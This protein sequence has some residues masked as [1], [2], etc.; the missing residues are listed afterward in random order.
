L[1][2]T[3]ELIDTALRQLE[4]LD[5]T[6]QRRVW[7]YLNQRVAPL[8]NPRRFDEVA[9]ITDHRVAERRADRYN[10]KHEH[11]C[12]QKSPKGR[13]ASEFHGG[14]ILLTESSENSTAPQECQQQLLLI[15]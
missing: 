9:L 11:R 1:A 12:Q 2:W 4:K 10:W 5:N 3:I 7:K 13:G 8:E 15:F 6:V 14:R